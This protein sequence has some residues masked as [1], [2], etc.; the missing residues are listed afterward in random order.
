MPPEA[1][2][3]DCSEGSF[4]SHSGSANCSSCPAY[5][6]SSAGSA[7]CYC[8]AGY[9]AAGGSCEACVAG[10]YKN[11]S[12]NH[13][14]T[15][16]SSGYTSSGASKYSSDCI[17]AAGYTGQE[18]DACAP[19]KYKELTGSS[20]CTNC[21]PRM[22]SGSASD[23]VTD[24]GP[25]T[26]DECSGAER[27]GNRCQCPAGSVQRTATVLVSR[28]ASTSAPLLNAMQL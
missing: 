25:N 19:G 9:G 5:S 11:A 18:C 28:D 13:E 14:C 15:S 17:C 6:D 23:N 2:C 12:G 3:M 24:C 4:Q 1:E 8:N 10:K 27:V 16:C 26:I 21:P 22:G 20:E 7:V